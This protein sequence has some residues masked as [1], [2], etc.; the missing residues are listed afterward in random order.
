MVTS[1]TTYMYIIYNPN[2]VQTAKH[3]LIVNVF[4]KKTFLKKTLMARETPLP[5]SWQKPLKNSYFF[6]VF[7]MLHMV[8]PDNSFFAINSRKCIAIITDN[9]ND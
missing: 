6:E 3:V 5:H 7:P 4:L 1:T 9:K 8:I 2:Y